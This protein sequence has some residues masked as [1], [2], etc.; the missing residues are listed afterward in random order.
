MPT[1]NRPQ[2]Q[3][4]NW[5]PREQQDLTGTGSVNLAGV[6]AQGRGEYRVVFYCYHALLDALF[7][8]TASSFSPPLRNHSLCG[9]DCRVPDRVPDA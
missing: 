8:S 5:K 3:A 9:L 4:P 6:S 1:A 7:F 2:P